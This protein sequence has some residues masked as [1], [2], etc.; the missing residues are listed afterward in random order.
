LEVPADFGP[1]ADF[2]QVDRAE[3]ISDRCT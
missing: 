2:A 1:G 3:V